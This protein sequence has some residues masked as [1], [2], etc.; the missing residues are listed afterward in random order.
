MKFGLL[1]LL[2]F[3]T[4]PIFAQSI[5]KGTIW[6][7]TSLTSKI[8]V[9][10]ASVYWINTSTGITTDENGNFEIARI[11]ENNTLIISYIGMKTDT[12]V[13]T[14]SGDVSDLTVFLQS[15]NTLDAIVVTE[16]RKATS[17]DRL[18][19]I[20]TNVMSEREL[21]KAACCNLSE[22]FETNPSIDVNYADAVTG[23]KQIQMLGLAGTYTQIMTENL[24]SV[25]G[26]AANYGM[27]FIP[28]TWIESIQVTKGVG[29]VINGFES[30]AGQINVE[31]RKPEAEEALLFNAYAS[32]N[33]RYESN[34]SLNHVLSKKWATGLLLHGSTWARKLDHNHD[35]F[36]DVPVGEQINLIN[37][38]KYS[39]GKGLE[40]QFGIKY[41][42]DNR[43]GGEIDFAPER[44]RLTTNAYGL[45]INTDRKE[46]W[47]KVGYVF[48]SAP[49]QSIGLIVSAVDYQ[50]ASYFG[51]TTYDAAQQTAY[52]NLIWQSIFKDTNHK[53]RAGLSFINDQ[54]DELFDSTNYNR[55]E[56]VPGAFFEYTWAASEKLS[57]VA[58][59]RG[60]YHN[61]FGFFATPRLHVKYNASTNTILRLAA[62]R[63]QRT[64]NIFAENSPVFVSARSVFVLNGG[65]NSNAYG[66]SPEVAWN[67][68]INLTHDFYLLGKRATLEADLH[69]TDFQSQVVT[70]LYRDHR[71]VQF[72]DLVGKSY[73]NSFQA[74]LNFEPIKRMETRLAYRWFDVKTN[75]GGELLQRPLLS[76]HRAF[77]N[78]AYKTK[79]NWAFDWT[80]SWF[81]KK[82]LPDTSTSDAAYQLPEFS[83]DYFLMHAQITKTFSKRFDAYVGVENALDMVQDPLIVHPHDPFNHHFDASM[84]WGPVMGRM[85]YLGFRYQ[86]DTPKEEN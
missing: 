47:G 33:G 40:A 29:S 81:S 82:R 49:Y 8:P 60:D 20:K 59:L 61:L 24:P 46:V 52:A 83:P 5:V 48:P 43:L 51:L 53:Y 79:D 27:S 22:S 31:L 28:G 9:I 41:L 3:L 65:D 44:D 72:Y 35:H 42:D 2:Y 14:Q 12:L 37:R 19:T 16:E 76:E 13:L 68:G 70:D 62:G 57:L 25:R 30:L 64:A 17:I 73:S 4:I 85:F 77:V 50:Q 18:N 69:R 71:Q 84:V 1:F 74:Q 67:M 6:S 75:Y 80:T 36:L 10:G 32:N 66:L 54:Y 34:L 26:L 23:A 15:D 63:G 86:I 45:E 58:G 55:R 11:A 21:F 56:I 7:E 38:W 78:I 39:S